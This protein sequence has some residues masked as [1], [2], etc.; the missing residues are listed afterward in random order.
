MPEKKELQNTHIKIFIFHDDQERMSHN[1][2]SQKI[3]IIA[4]RAHWWEFELLPLFIP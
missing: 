4:P 3:F 1:Q 2:I